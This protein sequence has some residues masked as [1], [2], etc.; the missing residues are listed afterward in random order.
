MNKEKL[1]KATH[2]SNEKPLK[3]GDIEIPCYV[4]ENGQRVL[5]Q[6]GLMKALGLSQG[7]SSGGRGRLANLIDGESV[8]PFINEG[9]T[10][11]L[12][13]PIKF[14][15]PHGGVAAIGYDA[16]ILQTIVRALSKAYLSGRLS[17]QREGIGKNAEKL[18][19]A[20]SKIGLIAL[21]DEATGY[22]YARER[23][24]LQLILKAYISEEL[25]PWQKKFPDIYYKELFRL[26]G[27]DFTVKGIKK[28][29]GVIGTWTNKLIYEQLPIGVLEELK[30]RTPKDETGKLKSHLHRNLTHDVGDPHLTQQINQIVTI[31]ILSENMKDMWEKFAKLKTRQSIEM[32]LPFDF[33][34]EGH[35][36]E[37][38]EKQY[39]EKELSDFN[40]KLKK[41]LNCNTNK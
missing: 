22:Q 10:A 4:L 2:G 35:T 5:S 8:K 3:I 26:N 21:I 25:L 27:W 40:K 37:L 41:A 39:E 34:K 29:P 32:E 28:R 31:F 38:K 17:K 19:D 16:E 12:D 13:N 33:D 36:K 11:M 20:F 14:T 15:P 23:N 7:S 18:D 1:L 9:F 30:K 6:S 24:E